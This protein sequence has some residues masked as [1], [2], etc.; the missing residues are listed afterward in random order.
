MSRIGTTPQTQ[1]GTTPQGSFTNTYGTTNTQQSIQLK[2]P[3]DKIAQ[4]AYEKWLKRGQKNG[5]D[6]QDWLEAEAEVA[7]ELSRT[8]QTPQSYRR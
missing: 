3:Y 2:A 4:R 8:G 1:P 7:A 5:S 6:V